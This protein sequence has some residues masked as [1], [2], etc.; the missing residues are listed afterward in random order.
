MHVVSDIKAPATSS[1]GISLIASLEIETVD[2]SLSFSN[3]LFFCLILPFPPSIFGK[4]H[5]RFN[6]CVFGLAGSFL[7]TTSLIYHGESSGIKTVIWSP[8]S[9]CGF[10]PMPQTEVD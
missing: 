6:N 4:R 9:A 8:F 7:E 2:I 5:V 1:T 3:S 10:H